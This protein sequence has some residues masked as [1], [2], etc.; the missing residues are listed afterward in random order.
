MLYRYS[1]ADGLPDAWP[2]RSAARSSRDKSRGEL[3]LLTA[4]D[5]G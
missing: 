5:N 2:E 4:H 3:P 1:L